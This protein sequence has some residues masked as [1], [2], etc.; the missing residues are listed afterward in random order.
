VPL[1][2]P[3]VSCLNRIFEGTKLVHSSIKSTFLSQASS[4][5]FQLL[6]EGAPDGIVLC[7]SRGIIQFAND[8]IEKIVSY[9]SKELIGTS[10][11]NLVPSNIRPNHQS[12]RDD[13][14]SSPRKRPMGFGLNLN[15]ERKDGTLLPVEISLSPITINN[16]KCVL[17]IIRDVSE[18]RQL[19]RILK[20]NIEEL[21]R[22]NA[23]L[24][25]FAYVASHDLQEPLRM[26]S[27]YTQLLLKRYGDKLG[28]E[29]KEFID[30]AVDGAKRMQN[31][32]NDLLSF[33]KVHTNKQIKSEVDLNVSLQQA[34]KNLEATITDT[35][36]KI[37]RPNM[38]VIAADP[39]HMVQ[40]FQNLIGNAIKFSKPGVT[41]EIDIKVSGVTNLTHGA[42]E[43]SVS[44]NGIGIKKEY[45]DK[46]FAIFQRLHSRDE[47][48]GTGIGLAICKKIA[49]NHN[50]KI[51]V[52]SQE[53][54]G[55]VFHVVLAIGD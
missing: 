28:E 9:T 38:P 20:A 41:P 34:L 53:G 43:I 8:Q 1:A 12:M 42:C 23:E 54:H 16:E 6:L 37:N 19:T 47:Y 32:I 7:D 50:G 22:S 44:D 29:G 27:G 4:E 10:I 15:A 48:P 3:Y 25:Q 30:F 35:G 46:I 5:T 14:N 49:E 31:L 18:L 55:S 39:V 13:Y 45:L 36:A 40:L 2:G 51:W 24:E 17:A 26:V 52:E 11:D 21:Q 33:S